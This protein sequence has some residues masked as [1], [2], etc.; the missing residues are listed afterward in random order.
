MNQLWVWSTAVQ[1]SSL[2]MI[3]VFFA[4][5][6]RSVRLAEVRI[7][8]WAWACNLYALL[9]TVVYWYFQV[10]LGAFV[11]VSYMVGKSAFVLLLIHGAWALKQPGAR[12]LSARYVVP[13]L[14]LFGLVVGALPLKIPHVGVVQH[15]A[16]GI[17]L[18][19]GAIL[20]LLPPRSSGLDFL[21]AGLLLRGGLALA[22]AAAYGI[23]LLTPEA[24]GPVLAARAGSFLSAHSSFDGGAE[25]LIAL[26][27]VLAL[28]D[29]V[30]RELRQA[31][32]SLLAAQEDLRRVA[33]R[34]P[35]TALDNRRTLPGA[36]R[37]VQPE[38]A[39]ILF[40]DL[41]GFKQIN[42]SYGHHTGDL[43]L[44]WFAEALRESFRPRDFV[45]RYAGDE[46]VVV[47]P[48]LQ[49]GGVGERLAKLR[50]LLKASGERPEIDFS[51]GTAP[52]GAG[53]NPDEALQAADD[54]MYALRAKLRAS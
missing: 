27:C 44:K 18:V 49:E 13:G 51:V 33:D 24:T 54:A 21:I 36:L 3:A 48:G 37:S 11:R 32:E 34:D 28:S 47:A 5:L 14:A 53:G 43:C 7:W 30:Q 26:G 22:E 31:N 4:V 45:V 2:L 38:G 20:L 29:R 50:A 8:V 23:T 17:V 25:W 35:L 40:F 15:S 42:D 52:L 41:D 10:S 16:M 46:F 6:S 19:G 39:L 9:V 1:T 12:L